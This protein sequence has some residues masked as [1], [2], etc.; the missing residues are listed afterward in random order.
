M[1]ENTTP[2]VHDDE[3][4]QELREED[5]QDDDGEYDDYVDEAVAA[6]D[7]LIVGAGI[8]GAKLLVTG[9]YLAQLPGARVA[10]I[11]QR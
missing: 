6:S 7:A 10:S 5:L 8:R 1:D 4:P 3:L 2:D 11:A 9:E